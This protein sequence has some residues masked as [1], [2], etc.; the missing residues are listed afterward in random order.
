MVEQLPLK[1][2]VVGSSPSRI[3]F[4]SGILVFMATTKK[5]TKPRSTSVKKTSTTKTVSKKS[6]VKSDAPA[7]ENK[8]MSRNMIIAIVVVV[9]II[10]LYFARGFFIVATVNGQ[11][12]ARY[13]VI[14][15]LEK[16][17]GQGTTDA[18][19]SEKLIAMEAKKQGI[20]IEKSAIDERIAAIEADLET[21]GQS[22][23]EL[24]ELQG[25]TRKE[26][27][28]QT[29]LQL[30]L[31]ELLADKIG[32]TDEEVEDA[33]AQQS[34]VKPEDMSDEEFKEQLRLSLEEQKFSFE[35]Q[36][37][38]QELQNEANINYWHEF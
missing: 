31:R 10:G 27:E 2:L 16:Q 26:V 33:F 20:E 23:D 21:S 19:I 5:S 9:L 15:E 11:P 13:Q 28:D 30:L 18:L 25:I 22:L 12:I 32:V 17:A 14:K 4:S 36:T 37:F 35:A 29:R 7:G 1:Q 8:L 24:L 3:T 6:A 38:V 34:E